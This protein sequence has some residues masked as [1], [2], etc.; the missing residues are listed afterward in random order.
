MRLHTLRFLFLLLFGCLASS[1]LQAKPNVVLFFTDDQGQE[2]F[3]LTNLWHD[4]G[5][6]A[7]GRAVTLTLTL[8]QDVRVVGRLARETGQP[9]TLLVNDGVL[10]LTL[11]G[12][13]GDLLRL[14]SSQFPGL[15]H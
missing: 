8:D 10:R 9:E 6:S 2:Y 4:Q 15:G 11:P 13:T 1:F 14:G 7:A 3:M 5:V 12:G